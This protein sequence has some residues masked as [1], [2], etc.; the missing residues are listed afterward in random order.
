[1]RTLDLFSGIGGFSLGLKDICTTVAYCEIDPACA[2]VLAR[3]MKERRLDSAPVF[4]DVTQIDAAA[5]KELKPV[6]ITAGSPCQDISCV[7]TRG[8]GVEGPKSR[9]VFE[10]FR[11]LK[12]APTVKCVLLENS[13]CI[14]RRGLEKV[15]GWFEA[16]GWS[17]AWSVFSAVE[18]GALHLRARWF[19]L[20]TAPGFQVDLSDAVKP[21]PW[22]A[23]Q[24]A[25]VV[26]VDP[27]VT[28]RCGLLGNAVVPACARHAFV[29][30]ARL[31]NGDKMGAS[32]T[33]ARSQPLHMKHAGEREW[34]VA[35]RPAPQSSVPQSLVFSQEGTVYTRQFWATPTRSGPCWARR[36]VLNDQSM[37]NVGSQMLYEEASQH[38][39]R[40]LAGSLDILKVSPNP[41]F[42]EWLMMFPRDWTRV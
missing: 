25:R 11:I 17:V 32:P 16:N 15:L 28:K 6:M 22:A 24:P 14:Q 26:L 5:L 27:A 29:T 4:P 7:N 42:V 40:S 13:S 36:R 33:S 9:L 41:V 19:C 37:K 23:K 39:I 34:S 12:D 35:R 8:L 3:N 10:V 18:V 1:M 2:A 30:L 20:A 38:Q 21:R 31:L